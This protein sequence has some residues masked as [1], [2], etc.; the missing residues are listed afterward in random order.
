MKNLLT[1]LIV[2]L[3]FSISHSQE[4]VHKT[5][6]QDSVLLEGIITDS[7]TSDPILFATIALYKN[8][9]IID[10]TESDLDGRYYIKVEPGVYDVE[11]S[12]IGY[13]SQRIVDVNV[14]PE[15]KILDFVLSEG[16]VTLDE[17]KIVACKVPL[18]EFN[19]TTSGRVVTADEIRSLPTK[20]RIRSRRNGISKRGK[21][22]SIRGSRTDVTHY[23]IDGVRVNANTHQPSHVQP[24]QENFNTEDYDAIVENKFQNP[25]DEPLS[26]FS[27]DVDRAAYSNVRRYLNDHQLPPA[28]AV[29]VEEMINYFN[30]NYEAPDDDKV[31]A[32]EH[33]LTHCPWNKKHQ[34][35]HIGLQGK[36][37]ESQNLPSSNLVF[38]IDVSGSMS[39][40]NKLPLVKSS[41]NLL[42]DNL[43]EQDR[44]AI[45]VYAGSAG[46]VL[47][48][49]SGNEKGKIKYAIEKLSSGGSTAGG[50]GIELAYKIAKRNFIDDGNNRVLLATDGDF[51]VGISSDAGLVK[52]IEG[53]R[54]D[55]IFLS[56]LGYG[57]GNYKDNKMQKLA[58]SGNGN[59]AY[60]DN[61]K[62]AKKTLVEEFGGTLFTIAKDVKIQIEFNPEFV[63]GYRLIGYENRMLNKEDFNDDK[64]DAGELGAGHT[65]TALYEIIPAKK[66]SKEMVSVDDLKYQQIQSVENKTD[67]ATI[68]LRY[69]KP[70]GT[71]S[72]KE[73]HTISTELTREPNENAQFALCVAE[74]GML[75]RN[76]KFVKKG[77]YENI[78]DR[79]DPYIGE[80][81]YKAEFKSLVEHAMN[82]NKELN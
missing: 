23:Y 78:L 44:I 26:T 27:I 9:V 47:P 81:E 46:L 12:Y 51:N 38:L 60:I 55:N 10:G 13:M 39:D 41:L 11:V 80:D 73:E 82:L 7:L 45:V 75:L 31:F 66:K 19:C 2:I 28:G 52:L 65:V 32:I 50:E 6:H 71:K 37:M 74:F 34:I 63:N 43:R 42:V 69:K 68:K 62:E 5:M 3:Q 76:S 15:N 64:K 59:H 49:T 21:D 58:D 79:I 40:Y 72:T 22:I 8:G 20:K 67:L 25:K 1:I 36:R 33:S 30:Y 24:Q 56:V 14:S 77:S 57:M 48:S 29:R 17:I 70:K 18:V 61:I 16:Q 4:T 35:L 53:K 54:K